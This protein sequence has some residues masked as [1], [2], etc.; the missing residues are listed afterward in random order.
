MIWNKPSEKQLQKYQ[1]GC[2]IETLFATEKKSIISDIYCSAPV[3][4]ENH[5]SNESPLTDMIKAEKKY[6]AEIEKNKKEK[7]EKELILRNLL[8]FLY[9]S[10]KG[11]NFKIYNAYKI[12]TSSENGLTLQR[13]YC[14]DEYSAQYSLIEVDKEKWI[15]ICL[16]SV[17]QSESSSWFRQ[18]YIRITCSSKAHDIKTRRKN[19]EKLAAR[20]R[21]EKYQGTLNKDMLY[22]LK[23]EPVARSA[24]ETQTGAK[25]YPIGLVVSLAQPFLAC[26]PD[27]IIINNGCAELLFTPIRTMCTY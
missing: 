26:S 12:L 16:K 11:T 6:A 4:T 24:F 25:I 17:G 14:P 21:K 7:I 10:Q 13:M 2:R 5:M 1:K 27:G 22:G 15:N 19:F 8:D 20:F 18:R 3:L 9:N 23:M